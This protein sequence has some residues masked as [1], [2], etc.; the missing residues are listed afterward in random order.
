MYNEDLKISYSSFASSDNLL[1]SVVADADSTK[2]LTLSK[3]EVAQG[4][5]MKVP[6]LL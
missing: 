5:T 3:R 6:S 2:A 4:T 1:S